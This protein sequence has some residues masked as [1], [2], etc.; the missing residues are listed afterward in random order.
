[1]SNH[2]DEGYLSHRQPRIGDTVIRWPRAIERQEKPKKK[3]NKSSL[4]R[5]SRGD[6]GVSSSGQFS[7]SLEGTTKSKCARPTSAKYFGKGVKD[8]Y[9]KLQTSA[10]NRNKRTIASAKTKEKQ[11]YNS[12]F[13][14]NANPRKAFK[15]SSSITFKSQSGMNVSMTMS[16]SLTI[17]NRGVCSSM[18]SESHENSSLHNKCESSAMNILPSNEGTSDHISDEFLPVN[19]CATRIIPQTAPSRTRS[20]KTQFC[21]D[22]RKRHQ[23]QGYQQTKEKSEDAIINKRNTALLSEVNLDDTAFVSKSPL[24]STTKSSKGVNHLRGTLTSTSQSGS[25]SSGFGTV[26]NPVSQKPTTPRISSLDASRRAYQRVIA[27]RKSND[28]MVQKLK[29]TEEEYRKKQRSFRQLK[30]QEKLLYR[31]EVYALNTIMRESENM[32]TDEFMKRMS[33]VSNETRICRTRRKNDDKEGQIDLKSNDSS[34]VNN[35]TQMT[36]INFDD[37][38]EA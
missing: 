6:S 18:K 21:E 26:V 22:L 5:R 38:M 25:P 4:N 32:L 36:V 37:S 17:T 27:T 3:G 23:Q 2:Y 20:A 34:I 8:E 12:F 33:K 16:K 11:R 35:D 9:R 7:M 29:T 1:M 19:V 14:V 13:P 30:S 31:N 10:S 28:E 24:T 15:D